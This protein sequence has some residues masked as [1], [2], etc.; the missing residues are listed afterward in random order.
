MK[1]RGEYVEEVARR[2]KTKEGASDLKMAAD[3]ARDER[4]K[5]RG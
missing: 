3:V 2:R 5:V 4:F 1:S